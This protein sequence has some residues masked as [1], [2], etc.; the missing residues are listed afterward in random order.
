MTKYKLAFVAF[1]SAKGKH[2]VAIAEL[3]P[4]RRCPVRWAFAAKR[5]PW[6]DYAAELLLI[7]VTTGHRYS[8]SQPHS[9]LSMDRLNMAKSRMRFST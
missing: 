8:P 4:G 2:A 7:A 6:W 9:L 1:D 3:R 5:H